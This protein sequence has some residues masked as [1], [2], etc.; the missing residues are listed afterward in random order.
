MHCS[1]AVGAEYKG[2]DKES[3]QT[4]VGRRAHVVV[5]GAK[6]YLVNNSRGGAYTVM[7]TLKI[8]NLEWWRTGFRLPAIH[9][10]QTPHS[11]VL[12]IF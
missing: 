10:D 12:E 11:A 1:L 2:I 9:R 5:T 8:R 6:L 4:L 7:L 3:A